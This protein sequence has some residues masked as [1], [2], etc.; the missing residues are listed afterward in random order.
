MKKLEASEIPQTITY[1][2]LIL[3]YKAYALIDPS[4]T[5]FFISQTLSSQLHLNCESMPLDLSVSTPLEDV[6]VADKVCKDC[7]LKLEKPN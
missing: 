1:K 6:L 5:Y 7:I 4:A 3:N 2:V